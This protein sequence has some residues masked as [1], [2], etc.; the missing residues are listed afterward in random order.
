MEDEKPKFNCRKAGASGPNLIDVAL[1]KMWNAGDPQPCFN[2]CMGSE[3]IRPG[4]PPTSVILQLK[5]DGLL[6][7]APEGK[8]EGGGFV[9]T[10]MGKQEAKALSEA[11]K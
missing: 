4:Q 8:Y 5:R 11:T 9:L 3:G 1:R 6:E 2:S 10:E 7:D